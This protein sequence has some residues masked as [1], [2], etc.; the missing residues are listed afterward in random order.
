[1]HSCMHWVG[2]TIPW[3]PLCTDAAVCHG[4]ERCQFKDKDFGQSMDWDASR[5]PNAAVHSVTGVGR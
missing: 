5:M 1:M 2:K 3:L 4:V